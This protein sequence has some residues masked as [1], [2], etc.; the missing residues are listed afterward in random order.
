MPM[1]QVGTSL[2]ELDQDYKKGDKVVEASYIFLLLPPVPKVGFWKFY[3]IIQIL[4]MKSG[5]LKAYNQGSFQESSS[6]SK[7]SIRNP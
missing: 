6:F 1:K 4:P 5:K 7:K 3:E 2:F